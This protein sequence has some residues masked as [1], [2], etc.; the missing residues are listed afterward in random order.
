M[1][2]YQDLCEM[3]GREASDPDFIDDLVD[4]VSRDSNLDEDDYEWYEENENKDH[5]DLLTEQLDSVD[6]ILNLT[7]P[8]DA[9]FSFLVMI[10]AHVVSAIEG[11]LAGVF[12]HQVCNSEVLTRKLIE[13]DPEFSKR[14]FTL[15]EI[16]QE[17][18][19]LKVTVASYLKD[20]IFHDLKKIKPMYKSVLGY[21]LSNLSWLFKAVELRHHCVH[22]AG[23]DKEGNKIDLSVESVSDLFMQVHKLGEDINEAIKNIR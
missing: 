17:Q 11:Y 3:Y 10:H 6:Q 2:D 21:E 1:S 20:L 19:A 23:Y 5:H 8:D 15:R 16:Y 4:E 18:D 9:K 12:I 7:V 22:R 13:S 14:K